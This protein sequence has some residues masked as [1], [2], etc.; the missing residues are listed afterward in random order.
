MFITEMW[1][2][3]SGYVPTAYDYDDGEV[4]GYGDGDDGDDNDVDMF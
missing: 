2:R 4:D 3:L 1:L